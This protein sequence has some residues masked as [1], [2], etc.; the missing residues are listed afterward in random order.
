MKNIE[1]EMYNWWNCLPLLTKMDLVSNYLAREDVVNTT[2]SEIQ[3][4]WN[5]EVNPHKIINGIVI[6][7]RKV[8]R[9]N[10]DQ[11]FQCIIPSP[12]LG[13]YKSLMY[14]KENGYVIDTYIEKNL[15]DLNPTRFQYLDVD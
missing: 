3:F 12:D 9:L 5:N 4:I 6:T 14:L 7:N 1:T 2:N 11:V 10:D 8:K 15:V 13:Y